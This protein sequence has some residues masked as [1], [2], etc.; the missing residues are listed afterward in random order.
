MG[1]IL[2][3]SL[4][5]LTVELIATECCKCRSVKTDKAVYESPDC[6]ETAEQKGD[7]SS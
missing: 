5:Y 4:V 1:I 7:E 6:K 2:F 3:C